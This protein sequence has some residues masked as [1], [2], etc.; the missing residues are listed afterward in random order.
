[1]L[2]QSRCPSSAASAKVRQTISTFFIAPCSHISYKY[3]S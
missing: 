1:M 2:F 3:G